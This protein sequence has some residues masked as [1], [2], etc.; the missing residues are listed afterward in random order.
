MN[1]MHINIIHRKR[2]VNIFAKQ[3]SD[4]PN[5]SPKKCADYH[6]R[7]FLE[8]D[9]NIYQMTLLVFGN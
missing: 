4:L 8:L 3:I 1:Y 5:L 2:L 7:I 6:K 9:L